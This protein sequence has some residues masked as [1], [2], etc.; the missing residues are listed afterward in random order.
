MRNR[1]LSPS[2]LSRFFDV[3]FRSRSLF[4]SCHVSLK[5]D[6]ELEVNC[7]LSSRRLDVKSGPS[8]KKNRPM[9]ETHS[10]AQ[11]PPVGQLDPAPRRTQMFRPLSLER[12]RE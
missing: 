12:S 3:P 7:L 8:C 11:F 6:P 1:S 4:S 2:S 9:R 10:S 5:N